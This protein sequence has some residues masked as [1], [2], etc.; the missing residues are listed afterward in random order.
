MPASPDGLS[1]EEETAA[2]FS[3]EDR[4]PPDASTRLAVSGAPGAR[5]EI[6][7]TTVAEVG[8]DGETRSGAARK[9]DELGGA[10]LRYVHGTA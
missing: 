10:T 1:L 8:P 9:L 3:S 4:L 6:V 5:L 2:A 7:K